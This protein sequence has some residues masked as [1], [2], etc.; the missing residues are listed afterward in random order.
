MAVRTLVESTARERLLRNRKRGGKA[1]VE[2]GTGRVIM[3]VGGDWR[4]ERRLGW[5]GLG[6]LGEETVLYFGGHLFKLG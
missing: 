3:V 4:M 1:S 6:P 2:I 5:R